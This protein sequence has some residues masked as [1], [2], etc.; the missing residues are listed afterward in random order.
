MPDP[1]QNILKQAS[2]KADIE[3][4]RSAAISGNPDAQNK[5]GNA[6]TDCGDF[7][8]GLIWYHKAA[9]QGWPNSIANIGLRYAHGQGV[10][11][12]LSETAKWWQKAVDMSYLPMFNRL[13]LM[14]INGDGVVKDHKRAIDIFEKGASLGDAYCAFN[15]GMMYAGKSL[16]RIDNTRA[17][18]YFQ[19]A[20]QLGYED[21][22][23]SVYL[24]EIKR[25]LEIEKLQ[26]EEERLK[27]K[28]AV[29][30]AQLADGIE[31][32][33]NLNSRLASKG[34]IRCPSCNLQAGEKMD[35]SMRGKEFGESLAS[36]ASPLSALTKSYKCLSCSY[37]W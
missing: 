7:E 3:L 6:Y 9:A 1:A 37:V 12:N 24:D 8:Q 33:Q 30:R 19:K 29:L 11:K 21:P 20:I 18:N 28:E 10:I 16:L 32:V 27:M 26:E 15:A 14:Y 23:V 4:Y 5:L 17:A 34:G 35:A 25:N 31:K 2:A 13:G 22:V 36:M